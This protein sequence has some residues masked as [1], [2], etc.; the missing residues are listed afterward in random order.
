MEAIVNAQ[1][2]STFTDFINQRVRWAAK[3]KSYSDKESLFIGFLVFAINLLLLVYLI[4]G[5][6]GLFL[7]LFG[8]KFILDLIFISFSPKWIS[9]KNLF[10]NSIILSIVYPIY[11]IGIAL[12]SLLYQPYWKGR[13]T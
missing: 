1:S 4:K 7:V 5:D 2:V 13:K 12:L 11:S 3:S 6:Y 8:F 9:K 10:I